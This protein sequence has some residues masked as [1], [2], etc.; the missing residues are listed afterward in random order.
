M[1]ANSALLFIVL[2]VASGFAF[3]QSNPSSTQQR[4]TSNSNKDKQPSKKDDVVRISVTLVQVDAVVTD[5]QGKP[6]TDFEIFED[7]RA[8]RIT[9]FSYIATR[10]DSTAPPR[11]EG[12]SRVPSPITPTARLRPDQLVEP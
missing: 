9:N 12:R 6:V 10:Q 1:R 4:E 7:G 5:R 2:T 11:T 3:S 8:Q